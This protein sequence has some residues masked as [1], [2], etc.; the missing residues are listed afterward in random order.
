[1]RPVKTHRFC[2]VKFDI[3]LEPQDGSCSDP[4][5]HSR[6]CITLPH[7]LK[8]DKASLDT[9]LHECL[10]ACKWDA[11]E[12]KV[13]QTAADI[14]GLLWRVGYRRQQDK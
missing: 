11:R 13:E 1:M 12:S 8:P 7:G 6:P 10:H 2:G 3:D 14:S 4:T 9:L 5:D